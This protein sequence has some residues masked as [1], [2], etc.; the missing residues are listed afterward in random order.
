[1]ALMPTGVYTCDAQGRLTFY[2]RRAA[3]LW[4]REP[5][6]G[7]EQEQFC[8]SLRMWTPQGLLIKHDQ[9]P[10]IDQRSPGLVLARSAR[11]E[12]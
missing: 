7:Q 2:N 5:A 3:Q 9:C 1:V 11:A 8:E 6:L 12:A 10:S 4:G